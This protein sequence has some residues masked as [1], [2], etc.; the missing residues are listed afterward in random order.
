MSDDIELREPRWD[1][2][3]NPAGY[4]KRMRVKERILFIRE[5]GSEV[6][7]KGLKS[8]FGSNKWKP[9]SERKKNLWNRINRGRR[10][11]Q[12]IVEKRIGEHIH[13]DVDVE[14]ITN[15]FQIGGD[16]KE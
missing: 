5:Y 11:V 9:K 3:E 4:A 13:Q 1:K 8:I 15:N 14:K 6:Q 2:I 12:T 10:M 16:G 7:K